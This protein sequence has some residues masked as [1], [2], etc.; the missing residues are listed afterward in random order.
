MPNG[1][2]IRRS[3]EKWLRP[4][5]TGSWRIRERW[6]GEGRGIHAASVRF[7]EVA[8]PCPHGALSWMGNPRRAA[9]GQAA[10]TLIPRLKR[11]ECRAP[12]KLL[13]RSE[14]SD[15]LEVVDLK[16]RRLRP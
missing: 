1:S 9:W 2:M 3:G 15:E 5:P 7:S 13:P 4:L 8:P 10:A 6:S 14:K 11:H 12:L 16:I